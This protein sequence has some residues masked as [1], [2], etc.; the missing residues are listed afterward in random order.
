MLVRIDPAKLRAVNDFLATMKVRVTDF[1]VPLMEASRMAKQDTLRDFD[2]A[3]AFSGE[4]WAPLAASTLKRDRYKDVRVSAAGRPTGSHRPLIL[5]GR[6]RSS[7]TSFY[8]KFQGGITLGPA[9]Y[10]NFFG[11]TNPKTGGVKNPSRDAG[12]ISKETIDW[13]V[14]RILDYAMGEAKA[15]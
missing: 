11:T 15:A 12:Y 2:T 8:G 9:Y 1:S 14:Q 3:G 5:S 7:V 4:M 6:F 10:L 13:T